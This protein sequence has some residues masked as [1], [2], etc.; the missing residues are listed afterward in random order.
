MR[1]SLSKRSISGSEVPTHSSAPSSFPAT[2]RISNSS[3]RVRS[4]AADDDG[5][6]R[7]SGNTE[8]EADATI[9]S[10]SL[11]V[12]QLE[13]EAE[14]SNLA[15]P[16]LPTDGQIETASRPV[17]GPDQSLHGQREADEGSTPAAPTTPTL[18]VTAPTAELMQEFVFPSPTTSDHGTHALIGSG[19][20]C[21]SPISGSP[22]RG[23]RRGRGSPTISISSRAPADA[24]T[25]AEVG[26]ALGSP[27]LEVPQQWDDSSDLEAARGDGR[28]QDGPGPTRNLD[29][30]SVN[31]SESLT[32]RRRTVR[33]SPQPE[34]HETTPLSSPEQPQRR[35][36]P[37]SDFEG[38]F[39]LSPQN[40]GRDSSPPVVDL[41]PAARAAE[42]GGF[43]LLS[44]EGHDPRFPGM[45]ESPLKGAGRAN[46]SQGLV[47][48][49]LAQQTPPTRKIRSPP[50]LLGSR[51]AQSLFPTTP[52]PPAGWGIGYHTY[53]GNQ[54]PS[55]V[56]ATQT[57]SRD[58]HVEDFVYGAQR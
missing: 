20:G 18:H 29:E 33:F 41:G 31:A 52:R 21:T 32:G 23:H 34:V 28:E 26:R 19:T 36:G 25:R 4:L 42:P 44:V 50:P 5:G 15:M 39:K 56:Y 14:E 55:R 43:D 40:A 17:R 58:E 27:L 1:T 45:Y 2:A 22:R 30:E 12:E 8:G 13:E 48:S 35:G 47:R 10:R 49:Q 9:S 38:R 7:A 54:Q 51:T 11:I 24:Q 37:A 16:P 6:R 3:S 46:P 53:F 57:F